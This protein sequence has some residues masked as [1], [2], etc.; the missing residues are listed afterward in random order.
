[1]EFIDNNPFIYNEGYNY[2][3]DEEGK[4]EREEWSILVSDRDFFEYYRNDSAELF[5]NVKNILLMFK[6]FFNMDMEIRESEYNNDLQKISETF[7]NN[8][9]KISLNIKS[10]DYN[11]TDTTMKVINKYLSKEDEQYK[12]K[13]NSD[14][15]YKM[16]IKKTIIDISINNSKYEWHLMEYVLDSSHEDIKNKFIT[17]HSVIYKIK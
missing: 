1:L 6:N 8:E 3:E 16:I 12:S 9:K 13:I 14:D 2:D 15:I 4:K 11:V 7:S 17:G 5:T 10:R